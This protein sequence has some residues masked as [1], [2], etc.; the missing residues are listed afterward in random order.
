MWQ[1]SED[2]ATWIG[3]IY[4]I[5]AHQI[6]IKHVRNAAQKNILPSKDYFS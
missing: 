6:F 5:I 4:K 1:L 2:Y 3:T